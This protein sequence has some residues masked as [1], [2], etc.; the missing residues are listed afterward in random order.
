LGDENRQH[1]IGLVVGQTAE[2]DQTL[3]RDRARRNIDRGGEND[4]AKAHTERDDPN[5]QTKPSVREQIDRP[6][7][8][9]MPAAAG[10]PPERELQAEEEEQ[11]DEA[12]L[13]D[14][15]GHLGGA[16]QT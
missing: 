11:E 3:D 14:K 12:D 7:N 9:R 16:D 15:I 8:E 5:D 10:K 6:A 2:V 13:R 1:E 4:C